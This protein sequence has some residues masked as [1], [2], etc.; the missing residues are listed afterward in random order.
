VFAASTHDILTPVLV[1]IIDSLR[2]RGFAR[3]EL[4]IQRVD[5]LT[6]TTNL[7][8]GVG[9]GYRDDGHELD[10][11]G[12]TYVVQNADNH[13]KLP[14]RSSTT[15]FDAAVPTMQSRS[16]CVA[17]Q[18]RLPHKTDEFGS[19]KS[20]STPATRRLCLSIELGSA[21]G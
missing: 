2:A 21:H 18:W 19:Q 8:T 1:W 11:V 9:R 15:T 4:T 6:V 10:R 20:T 12:V 17:Q 7:V 5:P 13:W 3:S 14:S 16:R